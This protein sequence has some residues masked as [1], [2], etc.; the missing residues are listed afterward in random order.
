VKVTVCDWPNR[1]S[2][3]EAAWRELVAHVRSEG[4][5]LVLLPETPFAPWMAVRRQFNPSIWKSAVAAHRDWRARFSELGPTVIC[6]S[7]PVQIG[8]RRLNQAFIWDPAAGYREVHAKYYLPYEEGF[9]ERTWF[10]RGDGRFAPTTALHLKLGFLICTDLWF[11][12]RARAYAQAGIHL[13]LCPRATPRET[14]DKWQ[15]GCR[16]A[17]VVSGAFCL[18][19]N[20]FSEREEEA[21][22]GGRSWIVGPDGEILARTSRVDPIRTHEIDI[23]AA[24]HAKTTY[25]RYVLE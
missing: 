24:G 1:E 20:R 5:D 19:A 6:A 17:A 8:P 25:P 3:Y 2:A 4:S 22:L 9:W 11:F 13:L 16:A 21:D 14:L 10:D 18:S 23:S 12:H 7:A 15:A